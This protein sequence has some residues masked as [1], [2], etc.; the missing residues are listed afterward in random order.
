MSVW[1]EREE[2][3]Q[4]QGDKIPAAVPGSLRGQWPRDNLTLSYGS[5]RCVFDMLIMER[6]ILKRATEKE[7]FISPAV[8]DSKASFVTIT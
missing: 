6:E 5:L 2:V 8:P 3:G 1:R 7:P 4:S